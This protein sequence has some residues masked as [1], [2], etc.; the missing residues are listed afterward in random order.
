MTKDEHRGKI[1]ELREDDL[2]TISE[3]LDDDIYTSE[4]E[5]Y[6]L[7]SGLVG[8]VLAHCER[9]QIAALKDV[10]DAG[11]RSTNFGRVRKQPAKR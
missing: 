11:S 5:V 8:D 2:R 9:E 7:C 10:A 4:C 6:D 3:I 1:M